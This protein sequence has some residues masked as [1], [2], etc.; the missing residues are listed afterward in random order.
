[1]GCMGLF[2]LAS[3]SAEQRTRELGIRKI[4]GA[5]IMD[6]VMLFSKRFIILVLIAAVLAFPIAWVAMNDW[7]KDFPY[8]VNI[9]LWVF[10]GAIVAAAAIALITVSFQSIKSALANPVKSLRT[11]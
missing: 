7:L 10:A 8:R 5:N 2:G 11:E 9:S 4:L 1:V 6:I 3:L